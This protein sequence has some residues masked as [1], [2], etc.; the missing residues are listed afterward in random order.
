M[1]QANWNTRWNVQKQH[2]VWRETF[3]E[4]K[5]NVLQKAY[6]HF[7]MMFVKKDSI[8]GASCTLADHVS[9][10]GT[11]T[12][13]AEAIGDTEFVAKRN[14]KR[15]ILNPLKDIRT[16]LA[17]TIRLPFLIIAAVGLVLQLTGEAILKASIFVSQRMP[18]K[19]D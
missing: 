9:K 6:A 11:V 1:A 8:I 5:F 3:Y 14:A 10:F 4:T 13:Y 18:L 7:R 2:I 16:V 19:V 15:S 17:Y 12:K